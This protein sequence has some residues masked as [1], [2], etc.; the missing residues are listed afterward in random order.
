MF[1]SVRSS[2]NNLVVWPLFS[3][4]SL[5]WTEKH[6]GDIDPLQMV[7]PDSDTDE[8]HMLAL[9][10]EP[11]PCTNIEVGLLTLCISYMCMHISSSDFSFYWTPVK[12]SHCPNFIHYWRS[13]VLF[14]YQTS[15]SEIADHSPSSAIE[16]RR[17]GI[18]V[19]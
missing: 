10:N 16:A 13:K 7:C 15:A 11:K 5:F 14:Y 6:I 17:K 4:N 8:G 2:F 18:E 19:L 12:I 3:L 9:E 1:W